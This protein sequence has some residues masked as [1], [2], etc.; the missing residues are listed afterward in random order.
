MP[1]TGQAAERSEFVI[2]AL[3]IRNPDH[4]KKLEKEE[5][6]SCRL[7]CNVFLCHRRGITYPLILG[8][9]ESEVEARKREEATDECRRHD[10]QS[11]MYVF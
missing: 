3:L 1:G 8:R 2:E 7:F 10:V 4:A 6:E 9:T 5:R 11:A